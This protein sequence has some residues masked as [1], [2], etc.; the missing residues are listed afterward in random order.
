VRVHRILCATDLSPASEPAWEQARRLGQIFNADVLLLHVV[1][2]VWLPADAS[3][4]PA[5]DQGWAETSRQ[6]AQE[7]VDQLVHRAGDPEG[8]VLSRVEEGSPG[9]QILEVARREAADLIV[10]GTHGRAGV[11]RLV[12]GSVAE[13]LVRLAPCPVLTVRSTPSTQAAARWARPRSECR[14]LYAT[15][16]SPSARAAW[17]WARVLAETTKGRVDLLHVAPEVVVDPRLAAADVSRM[18]RLLHEQRQ[19]AAEAFLAQVAMPPDSVRVLLR[20][21]VAGDE[22]VRAARAHAARFIV[23]GTEGSPG[24]RWMLGSVAHRVIQTAPCPVLT[25]GPQSQEASDVR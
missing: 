7:R 24:L 9:S 16:F 11:R 14:I 22:M 1:A 4:S 21:G 17:P 12:L 5:L 23:M 13:N 3:I 20:R 6:Q 10:M 15:D 8:K 19:A 18:A 2:P 25:V